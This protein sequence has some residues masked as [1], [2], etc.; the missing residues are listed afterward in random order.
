MARGTGRWN[1]E[2]VKWWSG[3]VVKWWSGE[4]VKWMVAW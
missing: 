1:G 3:E 4:V 2:V